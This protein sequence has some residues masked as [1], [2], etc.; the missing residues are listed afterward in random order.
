MTGGRVPTATSGLA[1][2][3]EARWTC[4][5]A[6]IPALLLVAALARRGRG[7]PAAQRPAHERPPPFEVYS[8]V[9]G[10]PTERQAIAELAEATPDRRR[11]AVPRLRTR[12]CAPSGTGS[13]RPRRRAS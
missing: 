2:S 8:A 1:A 3:M 5:A 10:V 6:L 9:N 4:K 12:S 11:R 7:G 13:P